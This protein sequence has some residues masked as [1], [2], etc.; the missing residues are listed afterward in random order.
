MEKLGFMTQSLFQL[1]VSD[2]RKSAIGNRNHFHS[3]TLHALS[4]TLEKN[5]SV[6]SWP[7]NELQQVSPSCKIILIFL[8]HLSD[9]YHIL[10]LAQHSKLDVSINGFVHCAGICE[11]TLNSQSTLNFGGTSIL[12]PSLKGIKRHVNVVF[13]NMV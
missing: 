5:C 3:P 10:E 13:G 4:N 6:D 9:P 2:C 7:A 1:S 11:F 12:S 8:L